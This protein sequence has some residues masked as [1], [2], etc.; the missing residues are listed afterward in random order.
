MYLLDICAKE[1]LNAACVFTQLDQSARCP[2]EETSYL[3]LSKMRPRFWS[4][5]ANTKT[6]L[7]LRFANMFEGTFSVVAAQFINEL[8]VCSR[9]CSLPVVLL[10]NKTYYHLSLYY[11]FLILRIWAS[12]CEN[13][14]RSYADS[15][16]PDQPAHP[17]SLIRAF[18]VR[19][20]NHWI[21]QN[22]WME[23]KDTNDT[24]RMR[25]M[26]WLYVTYS[27]VYVN[28]E[29]RIGRLRFPHNERMYTHRRFQP[30]FTRNIT[31]N[32]T[33]KSTM[34]RSFPVRQLTHPH[35][36]WTGFIVL[37][38]VHISWPVTDHCASRI[39]GR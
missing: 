1:E 6:D 24:L 32:I 5:C 27:S 36:S 20:Q 17:R 35:F 16:G 18:T 21:Q 33:A 4:D 15:E 37:V 13:L 23:S 34:L 9:D 31:S 26:I 25:R 30:F 8:P 39:S 7:N 38:V 10:R 3:W 14:L 28:S 11:V 29:A 2:H 12:P 19:L 22:I